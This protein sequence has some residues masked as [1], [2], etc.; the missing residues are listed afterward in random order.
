MDIAGL[1]YEIDNRTLLDRVDL[2]VPAGES[3]AVTGPSGSGKSSLL[4]LVLGLLPPTAGKVLVAGEDM[5]GMRGRRLSRHRR[6]NIG[7]VFQFGELLPELSPV[8]NVAIAA[9]LDGVPRED[10]YRRGGELLAQLGVRADG[11][12]TGELSG[13][14]RQ[15]VAVARALIGEPALLL[16]DEPTG[17]LDAGNRDH[18]ADLLFDLP[19]AR[20]CALLVVTHDPETARRADRTLKLAD[21]SLTAAP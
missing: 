10:A 19:R 11:V 6:Q 17:A 18:V 1:T 8:E 9:L 2:A 13:G 21:G 15:R 5:A 20:N 16:A 12:L 7:M 4:S 3:V 14:E